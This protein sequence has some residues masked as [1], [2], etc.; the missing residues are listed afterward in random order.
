MG[1]LLCQHCKNSAV[2]DTKEEAIA[3]IDHGAKSIR[4][5]GEDDLCIWYSKG[6]PAIEPD[7]E[8]DPKRPFEGLKSP[9]PKYETKPQTAQKKSK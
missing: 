1:I 9:E 7:V 3:K 6:I 4:C 8:I 5:S 2:A